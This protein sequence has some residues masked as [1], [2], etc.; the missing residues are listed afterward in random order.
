MRILLSVRFGTGF[1]TLWR[2]SAPLVGVFART[3]EPHEM[4]EVPVPL[5]ETFPD[6]DEVYLQ[7]DLSNIVTVQHQWR[8]CTI[9]S[10][11]PSLV[12]FTDSCYILIRLHC[13]V[14]CFHISSFILH[15]RS[16]TAISLRLTV[17]LSISNRT[18]ITE[19]SGWV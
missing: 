14:C 7:A 17:S 6:A 19:V 3:V 13:I 2:N 18:H 15:Q 1:T 4:K 12:L 8:L 10:F 9:G 5:N 11:H 16:F